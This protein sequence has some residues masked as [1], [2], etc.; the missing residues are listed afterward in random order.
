[1]PIRDLGVSPTYVDRA[2]RKMEEAVFS[3]DDPRGHL[4]DTFRTRRVQVADLKAIQANRPLKPPGSGA[5]FGFQSPM[6]RA[7][8][9]EQRADEEKRRGER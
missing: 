3:K 2:F 5:K 7:V 4:G 1:M 8:L 6:T 9:F